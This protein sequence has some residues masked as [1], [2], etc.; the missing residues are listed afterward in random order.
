MA[1]TVL[2]YVTQ[3]AKELGLPPD[4]DWEHVAANI[5]VLKFPDATTKENETYSGEQQQT[6]DWV[7]HKNSKINL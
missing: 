1:I 5:P 6:E 4:P 7:L 2:R 3:A